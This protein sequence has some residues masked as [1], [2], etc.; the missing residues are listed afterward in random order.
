MDARQA[1]AALSLKI[2][3]TD[4]NDGEGLAQLLRMGFFREVRV[5]GWEAMRIR[6]LLDLAN[7]LRGALRTFGLS[8]GTSGGGRK[9]EAEVRAHPA[10]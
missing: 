5:K 7:Q 10:R 9:F 6:T 4:A 3:K 8:L 1:K 2:N